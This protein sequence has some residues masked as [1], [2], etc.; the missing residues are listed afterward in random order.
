[1][2]EL[3]ASSQVV[4]QAVSSSGAYANQTAVSATIPFTWTTGDRI[5]VGILYQS[6]S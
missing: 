1:M 2:C 6:A 3:D 4:C 5:N